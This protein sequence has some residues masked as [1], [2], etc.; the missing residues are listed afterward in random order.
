[1]DLIETFSTTT[2]ALIVVLFFSGLTVA[3]LYFVRL[4]VSPEQLKVD[5]DV[6][7]F[8]FSVVGAFYGVILA[9]VI[10]AVW[11]RFE[12]ANESAQNESLA[13]SNLYNLSMGFNQPERGELQGALHAYAT[14]VIEHEFKQMSDYTYRLN[15]EDENVLWQLLLKFSPPNAQQ[16]DIVDKALDQMSALSDARRLR[17]VYYSEDLPSVIWI[18][19]YVGAVITL[20]FSYFFS[21][22]L[23]RSQAIMSATFAALIGLTILA[24]SEL[25]T[26]YQGAV[27]VSDEGFR[28]LVDSMDSDTARAAARA[29]ATPKTLSSP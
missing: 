22:R 10:V 1:M 25:A 14:K 27:V 6:A 13:L 28:F 21:T 12:R 2:Q 26:P 24:I 29:L 15:M 4:R 20:G 19:I 3:G 5:H 8:T 23:F 7:G 18:V 9:F 16:Q 11:Q 17:Y